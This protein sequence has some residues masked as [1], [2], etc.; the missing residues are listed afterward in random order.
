MNKPEEIS[1]SDFKTYY[2]ATVKKDN[3][4]IFIVIDIFLYLD[5]FNQ[6]QYLGWDTINLQNYVH[7]EKLD[8]GSLCLSLVF[9]STAWKST[10]ISKLEI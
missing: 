10:I 3:M 8:K 4:K 1:L 2:I 5:C 6:G 9:H 7:S